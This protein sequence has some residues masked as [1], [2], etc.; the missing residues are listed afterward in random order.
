[1]DY[2]LLASIIAFSIIFASHVQPIEWI[3]IKLGL[4]SHSK[5]QSGWWVLNI[6]T[7]LTLRKLLN[8]SSCVSFWTTLIVL[9]FSFTSIQIGLIIYLITY[10]LDTKINQ[11]YL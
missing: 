3:K 7:I 8:C 2:L 1:M 5:L 6:I 10:Y 4:A 9:E 11:V